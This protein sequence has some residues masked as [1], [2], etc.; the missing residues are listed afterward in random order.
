[1]IVWVA[2]GRVPEFARVSIAQARL[3]NPSLPLALLHDRIDAAWRRFAAAARVTL[4]D[5]ASLRD[6]RRL[7]A[8][9]ERPDAR[10]R[11]WQHTTGRFFALRAFM[12][13]AGIDAA[14]HVENDVVCYASEADL[15]GWTTW[16]EPALATVFESGVRAIAGLV[17]VGSRR[18]LDAFTDFILATPDSSTA[19]DMHRFAAFRR[20][21]PGQVRDLPTLPPPDPNHRD[22]TTSLYSPELPPIELPA[23]GWLFDGAR[24]GQYLGGIDPRHHRW[25]LLRWLAWQRGTV[26]RPNGFL[27]E[28]CVD[29]A[30]RYQYL[31]TSPS[32][33]A[34]PALIAGGQRYPLAT[35]HI[36]S[37]KLE[38]FSSPRLARALGVAPA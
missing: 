5:L 19:D 21:A 24:F 3:A 15:A 26:D 22:R 10:D 25:A 28:S 38:R 34:A 17:R 9:Y 13:R 33:L 18:S 23:G 6:D 4:H 16:R 37:K 32:G 29:T 20:E 1:M 35:L 2:I 36:H 27:N 11:F 30:N 8:F 12:E 14:T 31:V 7:R